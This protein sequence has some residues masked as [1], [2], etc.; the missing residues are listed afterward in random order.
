VNDQITGCVEEVEEAEAKAFPSSGDASSNPRRGAAPERNP[1]WSSTDGGEEAEIGG[2]LLSVWPRSDGLWEWQVEVGPHRE[3]TIPKRGR[4]GDVEGTQKEARQAAER[5]ARG[6]GARENPDGRRSGSMTVHQQTAKTRQ[7]EALAALEA[8]QKKIIEAKDSQVFK[9][10][11]RFQ[12]KFRSYSFNNTMLIMIQKPDATKLAGFRKWEEL[13][14]H[15]KLGERGILIL[16]PSFRSREEF[17]RDPV[18]KEIETDPETGKPRIK[19]VSYRVGYHNGYI[20]DVSQTEGAPI[21][22]LPVQAT[23]GAEALPLLEHAAVQVGAPVERRALRPGLGGWTDGKIIVLNSTYS[24]AAQAGVLAHELSHWLHG[25]PSMLQSGEIVHDPR[26]Q[27]ETEAEASAYIV[28][29]K[30]KIDRKSEFYMAA[31]DNPAA[32]R[33][34]MERIVSVSREILDAAEGATEG[35]ACEIDGAPAAANPQH[36]SHGQPPFKFDV[37]S[38]ERLNL[39]AQSGEFGVHEGGHLVEH[40][41]ATRFASDVRARWEAG[42]DPRSVAAY[43]GW[44]L[45]QRDTHIFSGCNRRTALLAAEFVASQGGYIL[46]ATGSE[47]FK[48]IDRL[49]KGKV[50]LQEFERWI[51]SRSSSYESSRNAERSSWS[52]STTSRKNRSTASSSPAARSGAFPGGSTIQDEPLDTYSLRAEEENP[53]GPSGTCQVCFKLQKTRDGLMVLHGYKRPGHGWVEGRCWGTSY[54][55]FEVSSERTKEFLAELQKEKARREEHLRKL[56]ASEYETLLFIPYQSPYGPR[57]D[58]VK[59]PRGA[60]RIGFGGL[61]SVPSYEDLRKERIYETERDLRLLDHDI[62]MYEKAIAEWK[63]KPW[64]SKELEP[65]KTR[66]SMHTIER[67]FTEHAKSKGYTEGPFYSRRGRNILLEF[68]NAAGKRLLMLK[69]RAG[70]IWVHEDGMKSYH[71][72][73]PPEPAE[74]P[75]AVEHPWKMSASAYQSKIGVHAPWIGEISPMQYAGLSKQGKAEY[76]AKRSR[77][78]EA[79][80]E[81]KRE[82]RDLVMAAFER[83]EITLETPGLHPDAKSSVFHGLA[84]R[85]KA[86]EKLTMDQA[87]EENRIHSVDELEVGDRVFDIMGN[88]YGT[89]SKK[90]KT[91]VRLDTE[92]WGPL[93]VPAR[94]LEWLSHDDLERALKD[95]RPIRPRPRPASSN[96]ALGEIMRVLSLT[97]EVREF[98][99]AGYWDTIINNVNY[100]RRILPEVGVP[101]ELIGGSLDRM[102]EAARGRDLEGILNATAGVNL[103]FRRAVGD[104]QIPDVLLLGAAPFPEKVVFT[105]EDIER[106]AKESEENPT[107][108]RVEGDAWFRDLDGISLYAERL[109]HLQWKWVVIEQGTGKP[110][111]SGRSTTVGD[112]KRQAEEVADRTRKS[113]NPR[114]MMVIRERSQWA[115]ENPSLWT[116][117]R[118][119]LF[120]RKLRKAVKKFDWQTVV[121]TTGDAI[122]YAKEKG[123][124]PALLAPYVERLQAAV[125]KYDV[126]GV[127]KAIS[128]V[129]ERLAKLFE[130]IDIPKIIREGPSAIPKDVK[131]AFGEFM[132]EFGAKMQ[133]AKNPLIL[134]NPGVMA[135]I[136]GERR[137]RIVKAIRQA[138]LSPERRPLKHESV[139]A[140]L[141]HLLGQR[142]AEVAMMNLMWADPGFA[143]AKNPV[144]RNGPLMVLRDGYRSPNPSPGHA[145]AMMVTREDRDA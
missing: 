75:E 50:G 111:G 9:D 73:Y 49:R 18:T 8:L 14:R 139:W 93:T 33:E 40:R 43:V 26:S 53:T 46:R 30:L 10:W 89:V 84:E 92:R 51:Y 143:P 57:K 109:G 5:K 47:M 67:T 12:G 91:S 136:V 52:T 32:L 90:F 36:E 68:R 117:F 129:R 72:S 94:R 127:M 126:A 27:I 34:S 1:E 106:M 85:R 113:Q 114:A 100:I 104:V 77:E 144:A 45:A 132:Q 95:G 96:P 101:P 140:N 55:P 60:V 128:E 54:A 115:D 107:W 13:D 15:V 39:R 63:P 4:Y 16:C 125:G 48:A 110:L 99:R 19:E 66:Y 79:S 105:A 3:Q 2:V 64:P 58:A 59:V 6:L 83:G 21:P 61:D 137:E 38:L 138:K 70:D 24:P 74:N 119:W 123:V 122:E 108:E 23:T 88:I 69:A 102:E 41:K 97:D 131:E 112:A 135:K 22:T 78:W 20:F 42:Q 145:Q 62:K 28:N 121:K 82:W 25:H 141:V 120:Y 65:K 124:I 7:E 81:A 31:W 11:L 76:D 37:G 130:E 118:L 29:Q 116:W 17:V 133:P 71:I 35:E 86:Q 56:Q 103:T 134:D 80:A 87:T 142:D 98:A 44:W